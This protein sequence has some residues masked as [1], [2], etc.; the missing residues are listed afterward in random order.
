MNHILLANLL[1]KK[2]G[3]QQFINLYWKLVKAEYVEEGVKRDSLMGISQDRIISPI[4][5]NI[6]LHEFNLFIEELIKKYHST[7]K[8]ITTRN[9]VYDKVIHE[10][11]YLRDKYPQV[12]NRSNEVINEISKLL[13]ERRIIPL[14]LPNRT[15]LTYIRYTDDWI[16]RAYSLIDLEIKDKIAMFLSKELELELS[17]DKTKITN[18]LRDKG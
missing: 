6:Y 18:L 9:P 1:E 8:C 12:A 11:Q 13:K 10:I 4:L 16:V 5:S 3:D 15:R 7:A 14:R 2:I 17:Q